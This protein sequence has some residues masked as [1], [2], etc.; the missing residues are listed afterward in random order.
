MAKDF[1]F[2]LN[3]FLEEISADP[4]H[5]GLIGVSLGASFTF[6]TMGYDTEKARKEDSENV[7]GLGG[8]SISPPLHAIINYLNLD[9][10]Y[11]N[12]TIDPSDS[13]TA[14]S[15]WNFISK[16]FGFVWYGL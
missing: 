4:K 11:Q 9:R 6:M 2:R 13:L 12:T 7:F 16:A 5:T 15:V 3:K 8:F 1:Y 10:K 14:V